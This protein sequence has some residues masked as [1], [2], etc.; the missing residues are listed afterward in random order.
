MRLAAPKIDAARVQICRN[1]SA[2][3]PSASGV[4]SGGAHFAATRRPSSIPLMSPTLRPPAILHEADEA[5]RSSRRALLDTRNARI[6]SPVLL[7][8][9]RR[10]AEH[11]APELA[12]GDALVAVLV[13]RV[14]RAEHV[15]RA[16][17][18]AED[19]GELVVVP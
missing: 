6:E 7:R 18:D 16:H 8:P 10:R 5:S 4:P 14:D 19:L 3:D 2:D 1:A 13:Q 15:V 9:P 17:V 12:P 11:R